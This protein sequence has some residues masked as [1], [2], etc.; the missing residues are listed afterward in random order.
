[1]GRYRIDESV[2]ALFE[3]TRGEI[4]G[5]EIVDYSP[6]DPGY[7]DYV[8]LWSEIHRTGQIPQRTE[9]DLS[10]V[11]GLT[12]WLEPGGCREP[13]RFRRYRRFTSAVGVALLHSGNDSDEVRPANYL[14]RDLI[15][16]LDRELDG[17][18]YLRLLRDV[19][20]PT[21]DVLRASG[22]ENQY[23]FWT[24][25]MMLLAQ[26]DGDWEAA[27]AA[28]AQLI[29]DESEVR[30]SEAVGYLV[31]DD[32]FLFGL[33][34]YDQVHRDWYALAAG[35]RNPHGDGDTRLVIEALGDPRPRT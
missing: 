3:F 19:F 12:A 22:W 8:K 31:V 14:A 5:R 18:G 25:G 24:F 16:D 11:I 34:N 15:V 35:L 17:G 32:R 33:S 29:E 10:E 23:P 6:G 7:P 30:R 4:T 21:R 28:A 26:M 27:H 9:F 2:C 13:V 20:P 1:M